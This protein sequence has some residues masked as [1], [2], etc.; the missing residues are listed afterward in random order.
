MSEANFRFEKEYTARQIYNLVMIAIRAAGPLNRP[1]RRFTNANVLREMYRL[2]AQRAFT[3]LRRMDF[4]PDAMQS[5]VGSLN[6]IEAAGY[7]E[8]GGVEESVREIEA[9][10]A[11][12]EAQEGR[13]R[14]GKKVPNRGTR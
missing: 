5:F 8:I 13:K 1:A 6:A 14:P 11:R 4:K 2:G 10:G 12:S 7:R 3:L 9:V